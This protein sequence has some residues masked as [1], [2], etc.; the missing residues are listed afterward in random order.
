MARLGSLVLPLVVLASATSAGAGT[1]PC[2]VHCQAF[3]DADGSGTREPGESGIAG[4]RITDGVGAAVTDATGACDL[5]VDRTLYRFATLQIPAG[6]WPTNG[7]FHHVPVGHAG[8]DTVHFGLRL[9][10]ETAEKA[11]SLRWIHIADT[12][13]QGPTEP[14]RMDLDMQDINELADPPLFLVNTG[15][16]VEVG[17]DTTHWNHYVAQA[18]VCDYEIF[19]VVGNHD[20]LQ[21]GSPMDHYERWVGP[22]YYSFDAGKWHFVIYNGSK[23]LADQGTPAQD[24]WLAQDLANRPAGTHVA[25]FQHFTLPETET[26]KVDAWAAAGVTANFSGHWHSNQFAERPYGITDYNISWTRNG[27]I[28]RTPRVFGIVTCTDDGQ[29]SYEQRRLGVNHRAYV[30]SPRPGQITGREAVEVLVQAYDTASPVATLTASVS[31]GAAALGPQALAAEGVSLWRTHVDASALG[32]G[33]CTITV[34]GSFADGT[35]ISLTS[36]CTLDDV[37][38]IVRMPTTDWPMFRRCAAGSSYAHL[39]LELPLG[40]AWARQMPGMIALNSPVV[41]GGRVFLGSRAETGTADA[42]LAAFDAVTGAPAWTRHV[43]SGV[44]MAPAVAGDVVLVASMSDSVYGFSTATGAR[45]WAT[46]QVE[47]RYTLTPPVVEGT[48]AWVGTEPRPKQ[49]HPLTGAVQW[50][51]ANIGNPWYPLL[52]TAPAAGPDYVYFAFFGWSDLPSGGFKIVSRATGS[53][54]YGDAGAWRAPIWAN[55][56]V[57][58]VGALD[59]NSQRLSARS[60]T[61]AILWTAPRDLGGGTGSPALAHGV[62]VVAGKNGALEGFRASDG[63]SLWTKT[64]GPQLYD[65]EPGWGSVRATPGTPAIANETVFAGSLD[66]NLYALDLQTGAE[67]WRYEI[68]VPVASSPAVSGN[69][70]FVAAEDAHLYAFASTVPAGSTGVASHRVPGRELALLPPVPNPSTAVTRLTWVLPRTGNVRLDI[71]DVTGRRVRR[72]VDGPLDPGRHEYRWDGRDARGRA[73]ASGVYWARLS[74]DGRTLTRKL[75]R[76]RP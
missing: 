42:G 32:P 64:V 49:V 5:S 18:A 6:Y 10:P 38:P 58:T 24:T 22:P 46:P 26:W 63:A 75:V 34:S 41:A 52:H 67:L 74:A 55:G 16:L 35:P 8:P 53:F 33:P 13:T 2:A 61:G 48:S 28:D 29:V 4:V 14:Y 9:R 72:V 23:N 30:S 51:S 57:Y 27:A 69:M 31:N 3:L 7:W 66:G 44:A 65:M 54:V 60:P 43:P 73:V 19:P 12:Q 68:G 56:T 39:D 17:P 21:T 1:D 70:V 62:I 25:M 59:R 37:I 47:P 20:V 40:L 71:M 36:S 45:V 11:G 76:L 15:D 50:T